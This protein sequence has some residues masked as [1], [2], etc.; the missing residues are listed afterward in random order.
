M[1]LNGLLTL[2]AK[3]FTD[4]GA[5]FRRSLDDTECHAAETELICHDFAALGH[6]KML[7][8][9]QVTVDVHESRVHRAEQFALERAL[10]FFET[11]EH[12]YE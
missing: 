4:L 7:V 1:L 12:V 6:P 5:R 8:D 3:V 10:V 11:D 9:P 2:R